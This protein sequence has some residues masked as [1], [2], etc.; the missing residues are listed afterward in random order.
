MPR[1]LPWE[2]KDGGAGALTTF[3][4][5]CH[6]LGAVSPW[7]G[8]FLY[9]VFMNLHYGEAVYRFLLKLDM[10]GIWICQSF[11]ELLFFFLFFS[12]IFFA[13][14]GFEAIDQRHDILLLMSTKVYILDALELFKRILFFF[15]TCSVDLFLIYTLLHR[16]YYI[17]TLIR[18]LQNVDPFEAF[19]HDIGI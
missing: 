11:G 8:S 14:L 3:L 5:W 6:L 1:L 9:H 7:I 13:L 16:I 18:Y 19:I 2:R 15:C 10:L 4:S 17:Y 12:F